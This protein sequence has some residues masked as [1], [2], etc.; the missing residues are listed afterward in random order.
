M[1][2]SSFFKTLCSFNYFESCPLIPTQGL[3]PKVHLISLEWAKHIYVKFSTRD[4]KI[5]VSHDH[6]GRVQ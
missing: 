1:N 4:M 6:R 2:I 5:I 3:S